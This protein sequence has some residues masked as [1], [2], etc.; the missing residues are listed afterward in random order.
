MPESSRPDTSS[1]LS[2]WFPITHWSI[3]WTARD[4]DS[5]AAI[6]AWEKLCRA[7]W[8]SLF[9][10][11]RR[12]GHSFE[13][14]EDLTQEFFLRLKNKEYLV[15]LQ[16][17]EGK[18]RSFLLTLLK[19]FLCDERDKARALKRGGGV[20]DARLDALS[21]E[22]RYRVEPA[23]SF[24][25]EHLFD[26]RWAQTVLEQAL[27]R[28]RQEYAEAG[29]TALFDALQH[30]HPGHDGPAPAYAELGARLGLSE[31]AVTSAI[32]RLRRRHAELLRE[33]VAQTVARREDI[34][35]E[36]RYLIEVMAGQGR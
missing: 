27:D 19:H 30:L 5:P 2:R 31:S 3:V 33:E 32:F 15:H 34:D 10:Y 11:V 23:D 8:G 12:R 18:F 28:L 13:E 16:N 35:E 9:C 6:E 21:E 20:P 14:A 17:R 26:R 4:G 22:E 29:K 24:S 7:Y 36:I 1:A 25:P